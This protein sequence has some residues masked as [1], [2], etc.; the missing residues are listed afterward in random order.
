[1]KCLSAAFDV[2]P[3][4]LG[5]GFQQMRVGSDGAVSTAHNALSMAASFRLS[6]A[7]ARR[8]ARAVAQVCAAW[9]A[10]F[11][12]TGVTA[13]DLDELGRFIDRPGLVAE[14]EAFLRS[15]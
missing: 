10:Q 2:L 3:T 7:A 6:E 9:R 12:Q 8:E 4:A 1:M 13:S 5:L 14:R 11:E 15:P